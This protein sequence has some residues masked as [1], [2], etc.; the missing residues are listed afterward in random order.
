MG[1]G[2]YIF[3][4]DGYIQYTIEKGYTFLFG[5]VKKNVFC[6]KHIEFTS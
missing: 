4:T 6:L 3:V 1:S 5:Q 2:F